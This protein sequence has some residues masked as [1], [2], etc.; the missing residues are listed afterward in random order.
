MVYVAYAMQDTAK[1]DSVPGAGLGQVDIFD[2]N[3]NFVKTFV[4]AGS[5]NNL[6][7]PWGVTIAPASFG[8]FPG[9]IL[10]GNFG[11]GTIS[12]FDTTGKFLG[13]LTNTATPPTALLNPGLWDMVFGGGAASG[14]PGT[15]YIT[16]GGS[17]QPNFPT[18]GST[19]AV[20]AGITPAATAGTDF[21]LTLSAQSAT[22]TPGGM[23]N[24]TIT[25]GAVG[26]F[27]GQISLTCS[28]P[29]GLT[30]ALN[31]ATISPGSS[32]STSS[33][34]IAVAATPPTGGY[35]SAA[36]LLPGLGLFGTVLA[37][38][39]KR[40][41][42]RKSSLWTGLLGLLLLV[43]VFALG[44]SGSKSKTPAAGT[45]VNVTVTGTSG[46]LTHTSTVNVTIN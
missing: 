4:A 22:I 24:L 38:R 40:F 15:L 44:C 3:G 6:N 36:L 19:T 29:T 25:A 12:A 13:Q 17:N 43:S 35:R 39:K 9:A 5:A 7:A 30:C 41:L 45:Q 28:A 32:A 42:T 37:A 33:L 23:S 34:S 2:T 11:D 27:N 26:G 14:D 21:S 20:F 8:A 16:A 31:P 46:S 1:H 18:G 10:V